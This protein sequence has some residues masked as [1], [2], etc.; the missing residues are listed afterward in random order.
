MFTGCGD[1]VARAYDAKSATLKR[2]YEGHESAINC[3]TCVDEKL[4]T[5][6]SDGTMRVWSTKDIIED[7]T[8]D[9]EPPPAPAVVN[10][11]EHLEKELNVHEDGEPIEDENIEENEEEETEK[12]DEGTADN[13]EKEEEDE[14]AKKDGEEEGKT[15][16]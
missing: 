2:V 9:D 5:G 8:A 1:G 11:V 10:D 4:F 6:S 12:N 15:E 14:E 13:D 3:L 16:E 7:L